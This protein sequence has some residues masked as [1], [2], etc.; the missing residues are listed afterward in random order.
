MIFRVA[1]LN[2]AQ[3]HKLWQM[4]RELIAAQLQELKPDIWGL[5][6]IHV[7]TQTGR[8]LQRK[9]SE[10][11]GTRFTLVQQTKV[12]DDSC[13]QAEGLLSVAQLCCT[14]GSS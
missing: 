9:T 13:T 3:D 1:T 2:L 8:W 10:M 7:P 11:L 6:E 12:N 5:N 4:R 14:G